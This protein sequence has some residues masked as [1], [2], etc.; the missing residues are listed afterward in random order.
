MAPAHLVTWSPLCDRHDARDS[1]NWVVRG[2]ARQ[3]AAT[4]ATSVEEITGVERNPE[5]TVAERAARADLEESILRYAQ[6]CGT[7]DDELIL[8]AHLDTVRG[9]DMRRTLR[10]VRWRFSRNQTAA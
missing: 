5:Q 9:A 1:R 7:N 10:K 3:H 6:A 2:R 8:D 4:G